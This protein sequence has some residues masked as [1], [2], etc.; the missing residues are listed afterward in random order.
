M[1]GYQVAVLDPSAGKHGWINFLTS[2]LGWIPLRQ[3]YVKPKLCVRPSIF[4]TLQ[5]STKL[6]RARRCFTAGWTGMLSHRTGRAGRG[7][8]ALLA[9][10][11]G[12]TGNSS[13][14]GII[15]KCVCLSRS[16]LRGHCRLACPRVP[17]QGRLRG[18]L[19]PSFMARM[20]FLGS[21]PTVSPV[22]L[23]VCCHPPDGS[24]G[25]M[26]EEQLC[27]LQFAAGSS[28][29]GEGGTGQLLSPGRIPG[30]FLEEAGC[31]ERR[32]PTRPLRC[33]GNRTRGPAVALGSCSKLVPLRDEPF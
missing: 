22:L 1:S 4:P 23:P 27:G 13:H 33:A 2:S 9:R 3:P 20:D 18:G 12:R 21:T 31:G 17:A 29:P 25:Q 10:P 30:V 19:V 32:W 16:G 11:A 8:R 26:C 7:R 6:A 28:Q 5:K 15:S 14:A 24:R